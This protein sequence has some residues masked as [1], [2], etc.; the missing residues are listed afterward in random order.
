MSEAAT[1]GGPDLE[2]GVRLDELPDGVPVVG[3]AHG[4][5]VLLVREG[6]VLHATGASCT[7][8]GGPL[9]EGLVSAG[10]V[11][12]PWH[13]G[14]FDLRT[15]E[16]LGGPALSPIACFDVEQKGGLVK[17]GKK[18]P[19]YVRTAPQAGPSSVVI[20]GAGPAGTACAETLRREGY[21]GAITLVG[22]ELPG[23]VDRPNLSKD[24][25]AGTAPEEWIP[26]RTEDALRAERIELVVDDA[27]VALDKETRTVRLTS[28]RTLPWGALVLATG[29]E[30]LRLPI[31]GMALP[32][33]HVLRTLADARGIIQAVQRDQGSAGAPPATRAVVVGASFIG[34]EA[35]ASLRKRGVAV[36][37]VG[38]EDVPLA[39][40]L[41]DDV[42]R[43]VR[44]VHE[45][46]GATFRLGV[47][48]ARITKSEVTLSDGTTLPAD[49]VVVGVGVS[50][51]TALAEAAG[52][53]VE[54]GVV[55]DESLR[56]SAPSIYAVGDV[57]RYPYDGALV[58]IEHFAVAERHGQAVARTLVGRPA[59]F[60]EV[61]F[62]WS[63]HHDV[64]LSH[65]GHAEHFDAPEVH[66]DL[67]KMDAT[68]AYRQAGR[69]RAVMTVGRDRTSLLVQR[70]M[71][72]EDAAAVEALVR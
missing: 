23:P 69:I 1:L 61:P 8:Y 22:A 46:H 60:R 58:R 42:G 30:P 18:R 36:T 64:T 44:G 17:V 67:A 20:V 26:L 4:E 49:L 29:A 57:A 9:G 24:Y 50:P 41:G 31:E 16:S 34:L 12:C 47:T 3:H 45:A 35:A 55:V 39:R 38:K 48:A 21:A 56:T 11:R 53:R 6:D 68:V 33:V 62:F 32:H 5:S 54:N 51:R 52:L 71:E 65:V 2:Q 43:F 19:P 25:L 72:R 28:G 63:Q 40:V 14:C 7:H 13:H 70:A 37:V 15:G 27:V 59:P 10:T 66:G